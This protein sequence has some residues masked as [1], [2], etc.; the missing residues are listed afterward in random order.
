M[1]PVSASAG[2]TAVTESRG[3]SVGVTQGA[4]HAAVPGGN[5]RPERPQRFLL[6]LLA[7]TM[8]GLGAIAGLNKLF[9][10]EMYLGHGTVPIANALAAHNYYAV[11]DLNFN[12]REL[13]DAHIARLPRAPDVMVLG[14]SHWQEAHDDLI[15]GATFYN[16]HVHRDYYDDMLAMAEVLVRH[17]KLPPTLI[18]SIRDNLFTPVADRRDHLWLPGTPHYRAMAKRLG[19]ETHSHWATLPVPRW[20]E[21]ISVPMMLGNLHRWFDA[22]ERPH[23]TGYRYFKSLDTLVPGGSIVWSREHRSLFSRE[24][25]QQ[26]ALAFADK[27]RNAPPRIDPAGVAAMDKLLAFLGAKGVRVVLAQ[28]PFNPDFYDRVQDTPYMAG[29]RRVDGETR[30]LAERHHL[31]IIGSFD[32][33]EVGCTADMYID[34]EHSNPQCLGRV[35]AQIAPLLPDRASPQ[36]IAGRRLTP[37]LGLKGLEPAGLADI[38]QPAHPAQAALIAAAQLADI[39]ASAPA[40]AA[41]G[42]IRIAT[43]VDVQAPA[44]V[45]RR[46]SRTSAKPSPV[47]TRVGRTQVQARSNPRQ[48]DDF[49]AFLLPSPNRELVWPGDPV[50]SNQRSGRRSAGARVASR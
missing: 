23:E 46:A 43:A 8:A 6:L 41:D 49:W 3:S 42:P 9:A 32:P 45:P 38:V 7:L 16:A 44:A 18:L 10:P 19:I 31:E 12:I 36:A 11:F 26:L 14:A 27:N 4:S 50:P 25:T 22:D 28:P 48:P 24:R 37:G 13:R 5:Q 1:T 30:R 35:L 40:A 20:R 2:T 29:L 39:T 21:Q 15:P 47:R 33:A 34:A 17:D